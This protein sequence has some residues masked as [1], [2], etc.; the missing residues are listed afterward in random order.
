MDMDEF[1]R[2]AKTSRLFDKNSLVKDH[3]L[4]SHYLL[5]GLMAQVGEIG[6]RL[7]K[8]LRDGKDYVL[9]KTEISERIGYSLWYLAVL[10]DEFGLSLNEI[11]RNNISFN[12]RR[13][14]QLLE[15]QP[16]LEIEGEF[17]SSFP[18]KE[19]LPSKLVAHF[20]TKEVDGLKKTIVYVYPNPPSEEGMI[21]FGDPIDDNS[22]IDDDY[23]YHDVFHFS[24]LV[25]LGW[26]PVVRKL[27]NCK[28][29]K[30]KDTDRIQDGARAR[31][32]EEATTAFIYSYV[33][34]Q[35]FLSTSTNVDTGFL[36]IIR[37]LVRAYEV[38][39]RAE[40][41]WEKAI[42][43]ASTVLRLL[44]QNG[45]GWVEANRSLRTLCYLGLA[46][47]SVASKK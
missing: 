2:E 38:A 45:G 19:R 32:T 37:T 41:E 42:I 7:K 4:A 21:K 25:Y 10:S 28:R 47:P 6:N 30:D 5:S 31:D 33:S 46:A 23:R 43:E 8:R 20:E 26:S 9:L 36:T 15:D 18:E 29:K 13:W 12:K 22:T 17:D 44:S 39:S 24:Y 1:Q 34:Q 11:A 14:H 3:V 16:S 40:K 35:N 27:L